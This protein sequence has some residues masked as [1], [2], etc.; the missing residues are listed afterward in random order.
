MNTNKKKSK[1]TGNFYAYLSGWFS[2][3]INLLLFILKIYAG[4]ISGSVAVIADAWHTLSD[5]I[6][7]VIVLLG[8]KISEKKANKEYP[9]GFG[10]ADVVA[11][12]VLGIILTIVGFEF[13]IKSIKK[14]SQQENVEYSLFVIIVTIFAIIIKEAMAQLSL[15]AYRKSGKETLKADA[16]HHRSDALSSFVIIIG[17]FLNKY[18]WWID[19]VMGIII[20]LIILFSAYKI[21]KTNIQSIIGQSP[22]AEII[23]KLTIIANKIA[24]KD[25]FVH[26][27]HYHK[28]GKHIEIS[29]HIY[30]PCKMTI[31]EAHELTDKIENQVYKELNFHTTIHIDPIKIKKIHEN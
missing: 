5:S 31:E 11:S 29:F 1:F 3:G 25:V 6:S 10:R 7:S 26:H 2:I 16:W 27:V 23:E 8:I 9:Y 19:S 21:L 17:I 22:G 13:I 18:F 4:I 14:I 15:F 28:Y 12:I 24:K 30:L 20:A